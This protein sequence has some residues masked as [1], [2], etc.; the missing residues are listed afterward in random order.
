MKRNSGYRYGF[1]GKENDNEVKGQGNQQDYGMRIYDP[2]LARFLSV[3]PITKKYP[4]LTLYQFASNRP[5][6]GIDQD[7][8]EHIVYNV[9]LSKDGKTVISATNVSDVLRDKGPSG[10]GVQYKFYQNGEV[11][12]TFF[13]SS[14]APLFFAGKGTDAPVYIK[15]KKIFE[16]GNL[17]GHNDGANTGG[18]YGGVK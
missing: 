7:G 5:I 12:R 6:D 11:V 14:D 2:R 9:L 15:G 18:E 8:L 3:D 16:Q 17:E 4:E 13:K 10:W 1:N